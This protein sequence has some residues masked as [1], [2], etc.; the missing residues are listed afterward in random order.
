MCEECISEEIP[1]KGQM[2]KD[3]TH[4]GYKLVSL[5]VCISMCE[6]CISEEIPS[7]GQMTKDITH[8]GY[9]I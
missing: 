6:E 9:K 5:L 7:K 4:I 1:S 2:T 8:I 3:I